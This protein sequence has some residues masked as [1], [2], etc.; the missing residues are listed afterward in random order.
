[1]TAE[2]LRN[3]IVGEIRGKLPN[4]Y[5]ADMRV[6]VSR[7][8]EPHHCDT[9]WD[10]CLTRLYHYKGHLL[11]ASNGCY[12]CNVADITSLDVL[13]SIT[14]GLDSAQPVPIS[15]E[16][17]C[18]LD[19]EYMHWGRKEWRSQKHEFQYWLWDGKQKTG[20]FLILREMTLDEAADHVKAR[21]KE[22]KYRS[23]DLQEFNGLDRTYYNY[24][25]EI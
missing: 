21:Y 4:G 15:R 22:T 2:E 25:L 7:E 6:F 12:T 18:K 16:M 19:D 8:P 10:R 5:C 1:M 14:D 23:F 11:Y 17:A 13:T 3:E 9:H 20:P 24:G